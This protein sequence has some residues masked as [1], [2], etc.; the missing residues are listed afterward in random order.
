MMT[1]DNEA[2]PHLTRPELDTITVDQHAEEWVWVRLTG[3]GRFNSAKGG[4]ATEDEAQQDAALSNPDL[5]PQSED[6]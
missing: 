6:D 2:M 3:D 1:P 4:F 5:Y